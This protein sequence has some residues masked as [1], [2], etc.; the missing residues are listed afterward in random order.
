MYRLPRHEPTKNITVAI[1][2]V[3]WAIMIWKVP[4][5]LGFLGIAAACFAGMML[6]ALVGVGIGKLVER[7]ERH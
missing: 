1:I 7:R 2:L 3:F 6:V 5:V 4:H